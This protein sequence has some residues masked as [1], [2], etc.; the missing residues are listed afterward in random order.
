[1]KQVY[2][3]SC[4]EIVI[5]S[6]ML[7]RIPTMNTSLFSVEGESRELIHSEAL[8][9]SFLEIYCLLSNVIQDNI[10]ILCLV[11]S[12]RFKPVEVTIEF[13]FLPF[14]W[15]PD[16]TLDGAFTLNITETRSVPLLLLHQITFHIGWLLILRSNWQ[17]QEKILKS[18]VPNQV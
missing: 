12:W 8:L 2:S 7:V 13:Y 15:N 18:H 11:L 5:L 17:G 10:L 3:V 4:N 1:M 6:L 14:I 9:A 16:D